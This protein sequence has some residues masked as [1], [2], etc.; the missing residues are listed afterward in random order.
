M[1]NSSFNNQCPFCKH[2]SLYYHYHYHY[3]SFNQNARYYY[4]KSC[5]PKNK[6]L[7]C[8]YFYYANNKLIIYQFF[9]DGRQTTINLENN[10]I[11]IAVKEYDTLRFKLPDISSIQDIK[12]A[13]NLFMLYQ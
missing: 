3:M 1:I 9:I 7:K 13:V 5:Q 10:T 11:N 6:D 4:C 12:D 2:K 8:G